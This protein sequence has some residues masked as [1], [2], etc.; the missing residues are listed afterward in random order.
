MLLRKDYMDGKI[1]FEA[2]YGQF[3]TDDIAK[4]IKNN[5][6]IDRIAKALEDDIHL[7]NIPLYEWDRF[8][9]SGFMPVKALRDSGD[10]CAN[11]L[12]NAVCIAKEAARQ[13]ASQ[14]TLKE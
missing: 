4:W 8:F 11:S 10:N 5:I 2:Y 13:L 1:T 3:I 9:I 12:S 14:L 7:N 6:G